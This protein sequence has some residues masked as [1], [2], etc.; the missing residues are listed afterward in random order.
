MAVLVSLI[1]LKE[2]SRAVENR[3]TIP[4]LPSWSGGMGKMSRWDNKRRKKQVGIEEKEL[5]NGINRGE[6]GKRE[7]KYKWGK[8]KAAYV[9]GTYDR[10]TQ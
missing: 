5:E 7:G 4:V 9:R 3:Y 6:V 2:G 8:K 10:G 1:I